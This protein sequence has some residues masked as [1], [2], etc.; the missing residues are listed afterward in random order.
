[1]RVEEPGIV[2]ALAMRAV[3]DAQL[4][5]LSA[6]I[7]IQVAEAPTPTGRSMPR[8][9]LSFLLPCA[10]GIVTIFVSV[11]WQEIGGCFGSPEHVERF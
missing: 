1:M 3:A 5:A 4:P 6:P 2:A 7:P 10:A 8:G 9:P 11:G